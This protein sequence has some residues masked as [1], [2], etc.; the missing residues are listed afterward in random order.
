MCKLMR[1]TGLG[2]A[3]R[4]VKHPAT[5]LSPAGSLVA[6]QFSKPKKPRF[7]DPMLPPPQ[8]TF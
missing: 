2:L 1:M 3:A 4:A 7:T 6:D 8:G 5:L